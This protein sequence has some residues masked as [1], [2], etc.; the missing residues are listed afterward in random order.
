[1]CNRPDDFGAARRSSGVTIHRPRMGWRGMDETPSPNGGNGK[2]DAQGRFTKGNA[3]GPGNPYG[4]RVARLRSM[5][6]EAVSDDDLRAVVAALLERA[7]AGDLAAI[8]L[9]FDRVLGRPPIRPCS[10]CGI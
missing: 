5:I 7:R 3:G 9:L 10:T 2:R 4:K 8:K 1:M 6:L